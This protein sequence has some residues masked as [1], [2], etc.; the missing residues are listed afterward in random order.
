MKSS[1]GKE[2]ESPLA[3]ERVDG[4]H[5][6]QTGME[7]AEPTPPRD[8]V[9]PEMEMERGLGLCPEQGPVLPAGVGQSS[10]ASGS[11]AG[12]RA[13]S[14]CRGGDSSPDSGSPA[15]A[16]AGAGVTAHVGGP[17]AA[18]WGIGALV[19]GAEVLQAQR[20]DLPRVLANTQLAQCLWEGMSQVSIS[21]QW[22]PGSCTCGNQRCM[23]RS[24]KRS[25]VE[26]G[27]G[28]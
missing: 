9:F 15:K 16:R 24:S 22:I 20:S 27:G 28:Y 14:P 6:E 21:P 2:T 7:A 3:G 8:T 1:S 19:P 26:L 23:K 17:A 11:W 25:P 4:V 5:G 12:A 10:W 13:G 18:P